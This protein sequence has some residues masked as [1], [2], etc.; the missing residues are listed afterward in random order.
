M[1]IIVQQAAK[2][3][4]TRQAINPVPPGVIDKSSR[5]NGSFKFY[6]SNVASPGGGEITGPL[7]VE[8][9]PAAPRAPNA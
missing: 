8:K 5:S 7:G 3:Q 9:L 6:Q 2:T 4:G 1:L